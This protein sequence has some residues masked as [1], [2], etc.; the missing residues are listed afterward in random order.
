[1]LVLKPNESVKLKIKVK[2]NYVVDKFNSWILKYAPSSKNVEIN[3]HVNDPAIGSVEISEM[4]LGEIDQVTLLSAQ[5]GY[6]FSVKEITK[7]FDIVSKLPTHKLFVAKEGL[8]VLGWIH[9]NI[10]SPSLLSETRAEISGLV[11]DEKIR[12]KGVGTALMKKT[13]D[14]VKDQNIDLIRLRSNI[15]REDAHK[16]YLRM[17]Y[18]IKKSWHFFVKS[19]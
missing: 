9:V 11:V 13:E 16:F 5:L 10:E 18:S 4:K 8:S 17:G 7:R 6:P 15:I 14:W 1:M 2:Y 19:F 3:Y 12:G